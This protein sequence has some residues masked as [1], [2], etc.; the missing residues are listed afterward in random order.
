TIYLNCFSDELFVCHVN[1][2]EFGWKWVT[3]TIVAKGT[4]KENLF[5]LQKTSKKGKKE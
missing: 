4:P 2:M 5:M 1:L 3:Q